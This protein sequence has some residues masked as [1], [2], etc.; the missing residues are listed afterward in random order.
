VIAAILHL[1]IGSISVAAITAAG[2]LVP[3][4]GSIE[5]PTVVLG[6]AIGSGALFA[7]QVNSNPRN[8]SNLT[9]NEQ[10]SGSSPLVGSH[11]SV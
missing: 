8:A 6:L 3:I 10:V 2:I 5:V 9:R 4:L 11:Y 1:A 7:L